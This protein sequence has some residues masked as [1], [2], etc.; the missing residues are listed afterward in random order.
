[1]L[2]IIALAVAAEQAKSTATVRSPVSAPCM[3]IDLLRHGMR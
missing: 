2:R 1:M 3:D